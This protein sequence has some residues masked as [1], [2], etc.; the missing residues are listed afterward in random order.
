MNI[1]EIYEIVYTSIQVLYYIQQKY[2]YTYL[3]YSYI[4]YIDR[5]YINLY[6]HTMKV[7]E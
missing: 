2:V 6:N 1:E 3:F 7:L 5:K 4:L